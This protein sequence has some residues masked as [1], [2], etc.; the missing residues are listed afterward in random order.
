MDFI[1]FQQDFHSPPS[2]LSVIELNIRRLN[3]SYYGSVQTA[4]TVCSNVL[5]L[6]GL[7]LKIYLLGLLCLILE[8][9][10][11]ADREDNQGKRGGNDMQERS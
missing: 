11:T 6:S 7:G 5:K 3:S 9:D 8:K 2:H 1:A 10:R 4:A